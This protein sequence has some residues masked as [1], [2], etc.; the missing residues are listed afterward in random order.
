ML[1]FS[2][3]IPFFAVQTTRAQDPPPA[4]PAQFDPSDVYFQGYL[5]TRAA[6]KLEADGD[7][8]GAAEKLNQAS[9]FFESVRRYYPDWKKEMVAGRS[10]KT[11][12]SIASV[13]PKAEEQRKKNQGAVAE[14][15][16]GARA[17]TMPAAPEDPNPNVL[18][19]DPLLNRRLTEALQEVQ[20]L[21]NQIANSNPNEAS[22]NASR[23]GDLERQ[24]DSLA[25]QLR[26]AETNVE[27]L[28]AR[29]TTSPA[30]NEYKALNK[31][32]EGLEM[33]R[34][35]M[36]RALAQSHGA[37]RDALDKISGLEKDVS[38]LRKESADLRQQQVDSERNLTKER[39]VANEVV[40]GLRRQ[41][42]NME[43]AL[44]SKGDELDKANQRIAGLQV[45]LD[46]SRAAFNDLRT[47]R[48][49][50]LLE[51]D[52]MAAL[53]KLN[54]AG[55]IQQLIEQNMGLAKQLREATEKVDRLDLDNNATKDELTETLRDLAMAK[56]QI[57]AFRKERIKQ[58][59][60]LEELQARLKNEEGA[61]ARG[62]VAADPA[63]VEML[64]DIIKRQIRAQN[65]RKEA[66]D[67]LVEAAKKLGSQDENVAR[68]IEMFEGEEIQ[69]SPE[70]QKL[71]ADRQVD[72]EFISPFARDRATVEGATQ[73]LKRELESYDRAATRAFAA[74]RYHPAKE[75]FQMV[76]DANPGDTSALCKLGVIQ[77]KLN[78][79]AGADNAFRRA[80]ELDD[81]NPYAH[82]M[83]GLTLHSA[84]N[85]AEAE[86][87]VAR[88]VE[89]APDSYKAQMLLGFIQFEQGKTSEAES[90]FKAA[91]S[92]D[93]VLSDPYINLAL[94]SVKKKKLDD[95]RNYY[96]QGLERGALPDPRLEKLLA[97]SAP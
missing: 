77:L 78:D 71:I 10:E 30:E 89:L 33:E 6:E 9:K 76:V 90:H 83:L 74:E 39:G 51:R 58:E 82:M 88:S 81:T 80:I 56:E 93:P 69:L 26:A 17:G 96:Q 34:E 87:R 53:L 23:V 52:Q 67:I 84:G 48:D 43:K 64:R 42:D 22:R 4:A 8:I 18:A 57:N 28:R 49:G 50:L 47:E 5:A 11:T 45:E 54:E 86:Q 12:E 85:S 1:L 29:L 32:I 40:A 20:R 70:E 65:H 75:L 19:A 15:E 38:R 61:L 66:R 92:A 59:K 63:E 41:L 13:R 25:A 91:I 21:R 2:A 37:H 73:G 36:A 14:L 16:G 31:R 3:A 24:R 55:R 79:L 97:S 35:G 68:A 95:A 60:R 62:E 7:F 72:G 46:Q 27:S 44:K 94:I